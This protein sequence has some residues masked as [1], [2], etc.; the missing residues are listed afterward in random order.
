MLSSRRSFITQRNN[1]STDKQALRR[2]THIN[3][4]IFAQYDVTALALAAYNINITVY[5]SWAA[6]ELN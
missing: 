5:G 3:R 2:A 4:L 6:T 1:L